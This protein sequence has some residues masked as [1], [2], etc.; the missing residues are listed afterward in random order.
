M[1]DFNHCDPNRC[2]GR[3]LA[4][5]GMLR[6]MRPTAPIPGIVLSPEGTNAISRADAQTIADKG[7]G[8]VDCSWAR[9]E[10]VPFARLRSGGDRLLPFLI[11]ANPV[12]YGKPLR[13]TCAEALA[14]G[15]FICG[16]ADEAREVLGKFT[17][18][19]SF[20]ELNDGLLEQ[21]ASCQSSTE[22]VQVQNEYIRTC[23]QEVADRKN[24]A[25]NAFPALS[26]SEDDDDGYDDDEIQRQEVVEDIN[27]QTDEV[28]KERC[29]AP[30]SA[31]GCHSQHQETSSA[32]HTFEP[33]TSSGTLDV[34]GSVRSAREHRPS[35]EQS[36]IN[37]LSLLSL[38]H[39]SP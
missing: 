1:W 10:E 13:L 31:A 36:P 18:G 5:H 24:Q 22:V 25:Y 8:V 33:V 38:T 27:G 21:Y 19:H 32:L 9:L 34:P 26:S 39:E 3:K 6:S 2:T 30:G 14:A 29:G 16:Y 37:A 7:L 35:T 23:E 12:N 17:W 11:A 15:L 28:S 4:R 20:F